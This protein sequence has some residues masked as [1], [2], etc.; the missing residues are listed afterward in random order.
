MAKAPK[1]PNQVDQENLVRLVKAREPKESA[2]YD[3]A[4]C[5]SFIVY[6][7]SNKAEVTFRL[8]RVQNKAFYELN[9]KGAWY[10][11]QDWRD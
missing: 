7:A 9:N 2:E 6:T 8:N 1:E 5:E 11:Y 3:N 4:T 10:C